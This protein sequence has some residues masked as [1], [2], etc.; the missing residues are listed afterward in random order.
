M[1]NQTPG[2]LKQRNAKKNVYKGKYRLVTTQQQKTNVSGNMDSQQY[3]EPEYKSKIII[4][5]QNKAKTK[6]H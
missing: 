1:I 4:N 3:L 2:R 6:I 5:R